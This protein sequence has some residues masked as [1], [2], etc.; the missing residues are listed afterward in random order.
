M[1]NALRTYHDHSI[2]VRIIF[3][4]LCAANMPCLLA[5]L[6][7]R[8]EINVIKIHFAMKTLKR[9]N[10]VMWGVRN[11]V[12]ATQGLRLALAFGTPWYESFTRGRGW[13]VL[14]CKGFYT[15]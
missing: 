15:F 5:C 7:I 1:I 11:E 6:F 13:Y 14:S 4:S 3:S 2:L 8:F 9:V 10:M 12:G